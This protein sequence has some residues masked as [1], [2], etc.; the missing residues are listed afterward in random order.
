MDRVCQVSTTASVDDLA[1]R[2]RA[3]VAG[4][5]AVVLLGRRAQARKLRRLQAALRA[6]GYQ[7]HYVSDDSQHVLTVQP[8]GQDPVRVVAW[9]GAAG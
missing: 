7:A 5:G 3:D 9:W 2:A 1:R 8:S 6:G 4:H